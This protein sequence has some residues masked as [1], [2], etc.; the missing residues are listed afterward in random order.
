MLCKNFKLLWKETF[1][2][3]NFRGFWHFLR[4]F[5]LRKFILRNIWKDVIRESLIPQNISLYVDRESLFRRNFLNLSTWEFFFPPKTRRKSSITWRNMAWKNKN[6]THKNKKNCHPRKFMPAKF[7]T[8][9][10]QRKFIPAK[11]Q[12]ICHLQK[13]LRMKV[14]SI[15][16]GQPKILMFGVTQPTFA[17]SHRL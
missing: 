2:R 17:N 8:F 16:V 7:P 11:S 15:R 10:H 14:S 9:A 12:N 6:N 1:A 13:F 5:I 3:R 4:K